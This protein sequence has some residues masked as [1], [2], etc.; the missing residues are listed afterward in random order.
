[1]FVGPWPETFKAS[2]SRTNQTANKRGRQKKCVKSFLNFTYL[3]KTQPGHKTA[4]NF[5]NFFEGIYSPDV[6]VSRFGRRF[7]YLMVSRSYGLSKTD[8]ALDLKLYI[9]I[10]G[11]NNGNNNSDC[12]KNNPRTANI[13]VSNCS[14]Y[15][16]STTV[17]FVQDSMPLRFLCELKKFA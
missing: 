2:F 11:E 9:K 4:G 17:S 5:Q 10:L 12:F 7:E 16:P 3:H 14:C 13:Y 6:W 8:E 15:F 1:M